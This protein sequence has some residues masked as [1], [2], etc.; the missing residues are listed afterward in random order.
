VKRA[1]RKRVKFNPPK[2]R[3]SLEKKPGNTSTSADKLSKFGETSV[4]VNPSV[5]YRLINFSSVF[6][7]LE[8]F[9][10]CK[11]CGSDVDFTETSIR[12]LGFKLVV[13]C[14]SCV[15]KKI[16]SC[17]F[18]NNNAYEVNCRFCLSMRL[19]GIGLRGS[20]KCCAFMDLPRP[21]FETAFNDLSHMIF[22]A[23]EDIKNKSIKQVGE[24]EKEKTKEKCEKSDGLTVSGDGTWQKCG[25][26][27]LH[28][29]T[30]IIGYYS[31]KVLDIE[32]Q[33]SFCKECTVWKKKVNTPEYDLWYDTHAEN[34][35][36]NHNDPAGNMEPAAMVKIFERVEALHGTRYVN[37]ISNGDSKTYNKIVETVSYKVQE[38]ECINHVQKRMG[39]RLRNC[40]KVN[41]G[42]GG[43]GKLTDKLIKDLTLYYGLAIRRNSDSLDN[44]KKVVWATFYHK[45]STD[46]NPQHDY[47]PEGADSWC[48]WQKARA[49]GAHVFQLYKHEAA[50]P[51]NVA[52]AMKP[53]YIDLS[54]DEL[55]ERCLGAFNQNSNKSLNSVIWKFAPKSSF[56]G[57]KIVKTAANL[58]TIIFNDGHVA[59]LDVV[60]NLGISIGEKLFNYC[61]EI[62]Q[63]RIQYADYISVANTHEGRLK[64]KKLAEDEEM[65]SVDA[66]FL[67]YGPGITD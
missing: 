3:Y 67:L 47:C 28:G 61:H 9:V 19:L 20:E 17:P 39:T 49:L 31:K 6:G 55:L 11:V 46:K 60:E 1:D 29:V 15:A 42:L 56:C 66:E 12:G 43:K 57:S 62:D 10:K 41:K 65:E 23:T 33:S 2:N 58:A 4:T 64:A 21:V 48:S 63:K 38:K 35:D 51:T 25:F 14:K 26:N 30:S 36:T 50:I 59:L 22:S 16:N 13:K 54:R 8:T 32:V 34:C 7:E 37:Y 45:I 27:S 18:V 53:I 44:M 52:E 24:I 40:K 5:S